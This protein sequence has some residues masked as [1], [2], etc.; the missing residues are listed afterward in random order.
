MCASPTGAHLQ[1]AS[2]QHCM[3]GAPVYHS[4]SGMCRATASKPHRLANFST[5]HRT[6]GAGRQQLRRNLVVLLCWWASS[7][8]AAA[9]HCPRLSFAAHTTSTECRDRSCPFTQLIDQQ[10]QH[11]ARAPLTLARN[12]FLESSAHSR[13]PSRI[14]GRKRS[15]SSAGRRSDTTCRAAVAEERQQRVRTCRV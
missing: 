7:A 5:I 12:L 1:P 9:E 2:W 13:Q 11:H 6:C 10:P 8:A 15:R 4:P 3:A 14:W